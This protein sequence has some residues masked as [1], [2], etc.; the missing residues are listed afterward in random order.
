[1]KFG[2]PKEYYVHDETLMLK[3]DRAL[4][5]S[6]KTL[7]KFTIVIFYATKFEEKNLKRGGYCNYSIQGKRTS[8][9]AR[10]SARS[11]LREDH[12]ESRIWTAEQTA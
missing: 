2:W 12:P 7:K 9:I 8:L 1:M 10:G 3:F 5:R 11:R 6:R 4:I